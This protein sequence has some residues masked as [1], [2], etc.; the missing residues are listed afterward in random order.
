MQGT[1]R[2]QKLS[3]E[4]EETFQVQ[5][6]VKVWKK[7]VRDG[8]RKQHLEDIHDFLDIH[9]NIKPFAERLRKDVL[10]GHYKPSAPEFV[11]LEKRD[12]IPRRLAIPEPAD[13][14]A[15]QCIVEVLE[16]ELKKAQPS[17]NAYYSRSHHKPNSEEQVDATF[18]Y[19]WWILW[20]EFQK[21]IWEF[22]CDSFTANHWRATSEGP[23]AGCH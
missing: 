6:V 8:L 1:N 14:L 13:A 4:L 3:V 21:R 20:L 19:P 7:T 10:D 5:K 11:N 2:A 18:A 15:L 12:G 17:Q 22:T 9:R 23:V 16:D